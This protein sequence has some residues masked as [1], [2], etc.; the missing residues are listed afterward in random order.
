MGIDKK[1]IRLVIHYN[2]PGSIENYYQEIGRAGRDGERSF[3]FLLHE[4]R[5]VNIQNFFLSNSHPDK[6]LIQN[7]YDA[8]CDYGQIAV[9]SFSSNEIPINTDFISAYAKKEVSKG[10]LYATLNILEGGG[11]L[12][13][14]SEFNNKTSV[15]F[16]FEKN[17]LKEFTKNSTNQL[18][19]IAVLYLIREFGSKIFSA[20]VQIST[21]YIANQIGMTAAEIEDVFVILENLGIIEYKKPLSRENVVLTA[22]RIPS[23]RL[24]LDFKKINQSY[25]LMEKKIEQMVDYVY[26]DECRFKYILKYFGES[27]PEYK[28]GKCDN[29]VTETLIPESTLEYI[30]EII[31]RT[32]LNTKIQVTEASLMTIIRGTVKSEKYSSLETF[33]ACANY[34]KNDL[35]IILHEIYSKDLISKAESTKTLLLT[36]KGSDYLKA[37]GFVKEEKKE[38][39]NYEESLELFHILKEVRKKASDKFMQTGYLICPDEILKEISSKKPVD[40][41]QLLSIN[42]FNNR[43]FNKLGEELLEAINEYVKGRIELT[44]KITTKPEKRII[45][46]N[47]KETLILLQKGYS[48]K[49]IASLR[50]L[51]EAV[52]SMQIETILEYEPDVKIESLYKN[53]LLEEIIREINKGY[54]NLKDLKQRLSENATYPLIRIAVAKH[55]L[56]ISN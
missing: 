27:V 18:I 48:L 10:L 50:Q 20:P 2:T 51:N 45:P 1:D 19:K 17:K 43:M 12:K 56:K 26:S 47:I 8:I 22:P 16:N 38:I 54:D 25:M 24:A 3:A 4:D 41:K 30:K 23:N 37:K 34:D 32:L 35:K 49:D 11:Y 14:P 52:V 13:Q 55:K 15:K 6:Q 44:K 36:G 31:L 46:G 42:G 33:G 7:V 40:R 28:C 5:D 39:L 29:C 53:G 9:E 21:S